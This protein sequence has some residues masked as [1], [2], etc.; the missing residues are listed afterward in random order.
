MSHLTIGKVI[1]RS[2][3]SKPATRLYPHEPRVPYAR[4]RGHIVNDISTCTFCM[5]CQKKCLTKAIVVKRPEQIWEIDH[6]KCIQCG[7]CVDA[8]R[9]GS[10]SMDTAYSPAALTKEVERLHQKL[11]GEP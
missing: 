11:P 8:C 1:T 3:L 4:T 9:K 2:A 5:L 6:M 7:A 10:L